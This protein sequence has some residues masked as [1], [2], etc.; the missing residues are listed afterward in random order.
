MKTLHS[1]SSFSSFS[2]I[3]SIS[4]FS[5]NQQYL[6]EKHGL[7]QWYPTAASTESIQKRANIHAYLSSH[8]ST[9]RQVSKAVF[10]NYMRFIM[11][12]RKNTFDKEDGKS[13]SKSNLKI[14]GGSI[15]LFTLYR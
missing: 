3:S 6:A 9:T 11:N 1:I 5:S 8:H 4:S 13:K 2:S 12:P 7:E 10:F 14:K 15:A